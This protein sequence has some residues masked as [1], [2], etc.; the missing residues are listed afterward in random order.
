MGIEVAASKE[1]APDLEGLPGAEI[2]GRGLLDLSQGR[3]GWE[4]LLVTMASARFR[5][6]GFSLPRP[7]QLPEQPELVLYSK[8]GEESADPYGRFN[9]LRRELDSFL[10]AFG[11]RLSRQARNLP[12]TRP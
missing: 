12:A 4:A 10:N 2:I 3:V 8:L 7:S 9:A 6:L 1:M 11:A 5:E